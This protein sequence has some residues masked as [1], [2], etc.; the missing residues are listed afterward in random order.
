M[1]Y[2]PYKE[3]LKK[4]FPEYKR[5]RKLPL[6]GGMSCPN[7]DGTKGYSGCTYCNNQSFSPVWDQAKI[8]VA[9]QLAERIPPLRKKY[10][11]AGILAYFQPYTN[12]Y[13]PAAQLKEIYLPAMRNPEIAGIAIGTRPDCLPFDVVELL[14]EMNAVKPIIVEVGLQTSNDQTLN[15]I[16]RR[17][18]FAEFE[19]A[20]QRLHQAGLTVT[21]HLIIGL[22]GETM[23]D[24]VRTA[25]EVKRL[26]ISAAK[27]HPLHIVCG[28]Q[29]AQDY[30]N[31]EF[32]LLSFEDYCKAVAAMIT[33]FNGKVAVERFSGESPDELLIAPDWCGERE[34]I[35]AEVEKILQSTTQK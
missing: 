8:S 11:D 13:A 12:T 7:L 25:H 20:V 35:V 24:F 32:E 3:F 17:H 22:P 19:N 5:V 30:A 10:P 28:T 18:T 9:T 26:K 4:V 1:E 33:E 6:H 21:T 27:L 16:N 14:A 2:V 15:A 34:K 29:M 31:G 23:D